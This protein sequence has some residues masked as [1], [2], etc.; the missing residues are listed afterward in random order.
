[1]IR[2]QYKRIQE[3]ECINKKLIFSQ[4]QLAIRELNKLADFITRNLW[5]YAVS[6]SIADCCFSCVLKIIYSQLNDLKEI[7]NEKNDNK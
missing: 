6:G 1:M 4:K 2:K 3:L 7:N 5:A